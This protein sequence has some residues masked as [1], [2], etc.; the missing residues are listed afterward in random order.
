MSPPCEFRQVLYIY[1]ME[2]YAAIKRSEV[3]IHATTWN[4]DL[5]TMMLRG[6]KARHKSSHSP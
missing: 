4:T 6:K 3:L 1:G 2:Y 5:E